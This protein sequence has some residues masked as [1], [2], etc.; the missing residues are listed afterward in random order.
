M[1]YYWMK[2]L[3]CINKIYYNYKL[4]IY[5]YDIICK[6][7]MSYTIINNNSYI[8]LSIDL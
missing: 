3:W 5:K 4:Y 7:Y 2:G 1:N 6:L 8:F